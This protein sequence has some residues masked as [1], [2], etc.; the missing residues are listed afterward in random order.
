MAHRIRKLLAIVQILLQLCPPSFLLYLAPTFNASAEEKITSDTSLQNNKNNQGN[1][2]NGVAQAAVQAGTLLSGDDTSGALGNALTSAATG[3]AS[4]EVQQWLNK[5]GTARVNIST[6]EHFTLND[7]ELDVL[8]PLYNQKENILFTQLGGRR[9]DD[10]NIINTGLGYR[11]FSGIW[12]WGTNVFYDRQVSGNQH[13]RLGVGAELGWDYI[14][15][16]ANGYFRLSDWMSS[17]RYT[18]YD[19]RVANGFDIRATGYLPSYP[20]LGA[21]VIY[22]QYYGDSVGLFGDDKDDRQKNPHAVTFGLNY[23][24][25]PLVTFGVNQKLGKGGENDTQLNL[26]LNWTPGVPLRD[27]LDPSMISQRRSLLGSRL[28]LVDRNNNIVL[29]YRKQDIISLSLPPQ[30]EGEEQSKQ[31]VTAKVKTKYGLDHIEW[32]AASFLNDGGKIAV[33][34]SPE[35]FVLTLP[36]WQSSGTN[37]YTLRATA[38]DKKGNASN[39]SEMKVNVSGIDVNTLQSTTTVSPTKI[40]ADGATTATVRVSLQTS[41]GE[42]AAGLAS[43]L[44]ATLT[45]SASSPAQATNTVTEKSTTIT[46]FNETSP[47]QYTATITA[48][49]TPDTLTIQPLIDSTIKL[50]SAK[51]IEEAAIAI[52]QLTGLDTFSTSTIANGGTPITL[53]AHVTDQYGN[54]LKDAVIDWSADNAQAHLSAAQSSTDANGTAQIQVTSAEVINTVVTAK[55]AEGNSLSTPTLSFTADTATAKVASIASE[56]TQVVA[57]NTDKSTVTAQVTDNYSHPLAGVTVKWTVEK[58]DDTKV[59]NKTSVT[60]SQGMATIDLKSAKTGTITVTAEVNGNSSQETDPITFVADSSTERVTSVKLSKSQALANGSDAI[61]YEATVSDAAGNA[62]QNATVTWS[63]D[64]TDVILSDTQTSSDINGKSQI[65][66]TSHKAGNVVVTA[67]TSASTGYQSD[68][69]TFTADAGSAS[70]SDLVSDRESALAN[71]SDGITLS[72]TVKDTNGNPVANADVNWSVSPATGSLSANSSKTDSTGVAKITLTSAEVATYGVTAEING[73]TDKASLTFIAD[74]STAHLTSLTAEPTTSVLADGTSA[75]NLTATVVDQFGHPVKNEQI[76]W[77]ADNA[78][79]QL[80]STQSITDAQ[81]QAKIKVTSADVM[82]TVV[83]AQHNQAEAL[84]TDSLSFTADTTSAV[85]HTIDANKYQ[86]IANNIDTSTATAQVV[87]RYSHPLSGVTVNWQVTKADGTSAGTATS[88]TDNQGTATFTL[89]SAKTGSVTVSAGVNGASDVKKTNTITFV[90]DSSSERVSLVKPS[91]NQATANGRDEVIYEAI[92]T[93]AQNNPVAN[94]TVDWSAD[95]TDAKLSVNQTTS[96]A[97]GKSQISVTSLKASEVVITAQTSASTAMPADSVHF[98]ADA[99]T[100]KID[101]VVSNKPTALA[102][103]TDAMTISATVTDING[104]PLAD[105]DVSWEVTPATGVLSAQSSRTT[106]EGVA[107]V[108]LTSTEVASLSVKAS[109][110]G[111]QG[112]ASNLNFTADSTTAHVALLEADKTLDIVADKDTVALTATVLDSNQHPVSGVTVNWS[113]SE[114]NSSFSVNSSVTDAQ[115]KATATFSSLKAGSIVVT[116]AT[117]GGTGQTQTLQVTGNTATAQVTGITP[118]KTQEVANG[119]SMITWTAAVVD[120][121]DNVLKNVTINWAANRDDVTLTP[122]SSVS[123]D[124]GHATTQSVSLKS[125]KVTLTATPANHTA[126][127]KTDG[128]AVFIGDTQTAHVAKLTPNETR[129]MTNGVGATYTATV[130]DANDNPVTGVTVTW[131]ANINTLSA[132][133]STTNSAGEAKMTLK[134]GTKGLATVTATANGSTLKDQSVTFADIVQYDWNITGTTSTYKGDTITGYPAV[135]FIVTGDTQVQ[136]SNTLIWDSTAYGSSTLIMPMQDDAGATHNVIFTGQR[137]N[138]CG[139]HALNNAVACS[140]GNNYPKLVYKSAD[141]PDLPAGHYTAHITFDGQEW[142]NKARLLAYDI[143]TSL[144][145]E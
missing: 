86:V 145:V 16:S 22:E 134:G 51:L 135:G 62:I 66:V 33:G 3:A 139:A 20:Q 43:R 121:N 102:N 68:K 21:N 70:I 53:T 116:A 58:T 9:H 44:S 115:G 131:T 34:S 129:V 82:T 133:S 31:N 100:A 55:L 69:A 130:N 101:S 49:T 137:D 29:E 91:K 122:T 30:L 124:N 1:T 32:Q 90:A 108:Q 60:D 73:S 79:A 42:S 46:R 85:V 78:K 13:E 95:N 98:V 50:A 141:N 142:H 11:H 36:A 99:S 93:D 81:G 12:M 112:A 111:T 87:D 7:S 5:F 23:T 54:A 25:V 76:N 4:A 118:D 84:H 6:D 35:Q 126:G 41:S 104:N 107:Q 27:Q 71:G 61:I 120:A 92:V 106:A 18:D 140:T 89:K 132:D 2:E 65:Q 113:S 10:R 96:D 72:A 37:S 17:N 74:T 144:T 59:G 24:P 103:G 88:V 136:G 123:D 48:G 19:E 38:W 47:G 97:N 45:T 15:L 63:S 57:N 40:P 52:P 119:T 143:N 64:N 127:Q 125:G 56:K 114:T 77:S 117:T 28:D 138:E 8:L 39:N 109:I 26:A 94:A 14:K 105:A 110:N 80:S 128:E 67:Q 83:T 75:I